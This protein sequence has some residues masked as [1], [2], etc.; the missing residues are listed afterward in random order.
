MIQMLPWMMQQQPLQCTHSPRAQADVSIG[1][2]AAA[3]SMVASGS[4]AFFSSLSKYFCTSADASSLYPS[5]STTITA[6]FLTVKLSPLD[7]VV[8]FIASTPYWM[9]SSR[10]K[11]ANFEVLLQ[12]G[13]C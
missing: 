2:A 3:S 11:S 1:A 13:L 10:G 9:R 6:V 8:L 12:V 5:L 4:S 7:T